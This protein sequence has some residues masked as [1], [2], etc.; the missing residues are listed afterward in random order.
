MDFEFAIVSNEPEITKFIHKMIDVRPSGTDHFS[1]HRL[2]HVSAV[3]AR[4]TELAD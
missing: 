3:S 4:E 1:Q 2:S